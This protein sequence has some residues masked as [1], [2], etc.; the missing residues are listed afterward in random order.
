ME[1]LKTFGITALAAMVGFAVYDQLV[2]GL[3]TKKA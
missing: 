3:L 2:K 1:H